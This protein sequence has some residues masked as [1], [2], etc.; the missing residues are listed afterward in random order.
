MS[1]LEARLQ[2]LVERDTC[3]RHRETLARLLREAQVKLM[4][5]A[6]IR[7]RPHFAANLIQRIDAVLAEVEVQ[8]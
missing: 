4:A 3:L 7:Q 8:R 1:F 5:P 2:A 6:D